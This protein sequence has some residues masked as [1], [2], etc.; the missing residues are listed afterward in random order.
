MAIPYDLTCWYLNARRIVELA[1]DFLPS[2]QYT[3]DVHLSKLRR[4]SELKKALISWMTTVGP[5]P[6]EVLLSSGTLTTGSMFTHHSNYYFVGLRKSYEER[7]NGKDVEPALAYSKLEE[8]KKGGRVSFDFHDEHLTSASSW[9]ELS[10]H[11]RKFALGL[12]TDIQGKNIRAI[13]Y[14]FAN[15]ID[16]FSE[17]AG[18][19]GVWTN[20]LEV[21]VEQIDS[22][23]EI[24]NNEGQPQKTDLQKLKNISESQVKSAFA[25]I[26]GEPNIP[27][28]W[29]GESSDLFT[30]RLLVGDQR[31]S[32]AFLLKGPSKFHPMTP[33][34]L[35]KN[36]DQIGRLFDE[37]ADLLILQHCHEVRNGVRRQM[38]AYAHQMGNPRRFCIIDGYDTLR[39][40]AAY[41]KCGVPNLVGGGT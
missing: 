3:G 40:L 1:G 34:D 2:T 18:F 21:F 23:S 30:S 37:P 38:R 13:P 14:V 12:V 8:W 4:L 17:L 29:G 15:I 33:S 41:N 26:I 9:T 20:Y 16:P 28:D 6:L 24:R 11:R 27:K 39:I 7:M 5:P 10:G 25:E 31:V 36:G 32:S 19:S 22:F 35:G